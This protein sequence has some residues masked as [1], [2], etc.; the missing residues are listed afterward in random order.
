MKKKKIPHRFE[1]IKCVDMKFRGHSCNLATA[2]YNMYSY[3]K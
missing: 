3:E 1:K 2:L